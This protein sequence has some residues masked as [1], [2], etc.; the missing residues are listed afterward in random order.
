MADLT[1]ENYGT[2]I[3]R[4]SNGNEYWVKFLTNAWGK[5]V[6]PQLE[7]EEV[8]NAPDIFAAKSIAMRIHQGLLNQQ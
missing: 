3:V 5:K 4:N 1:C 8:R 2:P 7:I 6:I